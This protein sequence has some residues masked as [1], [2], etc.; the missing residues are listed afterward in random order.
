M[1][2]GQAICGNQ[3]LEMRNN[4]KTGRIMLENSAQQGKRRKMPN[5][6]WQRRNR[7][8]EA[9]ASFDPRSSAARRRSAELSP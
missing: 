3:L 7:G 4:G 5:L 1:T 2:T 8:D 9:S 6:A